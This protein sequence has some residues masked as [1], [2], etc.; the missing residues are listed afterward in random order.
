MDIQCLFFFPLTLLCLAVL[1][2][3]L[4]DYSYYPLFFP[5]RPF[6]LPPC[7]APPSRPTRCIAGNNVFPSSGWRFEPPTPPS[8][9]FLSPSS[10]R[11]PSFLEPACP[12]A[13]RA[14]CML[15]RTPTQKEAKLPKANS[16]HTRQ[17]TQQ[18]TKQRTGCGHPR[19]H[20]STT[21]SRSHTRAVRWAASA[22]HQSP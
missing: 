6:P 3:V 17:R 10:A 16:T 12:A 20:I 13:T 19:Q 22:A 9:L 5:S 8:P 4:C 1:C 11:F 18:H 15:L 21:T 2:I 14:E 7:K